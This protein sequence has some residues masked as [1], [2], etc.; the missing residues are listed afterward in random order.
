MKKRNGLTNLFYVIILLSLVGFLAVE[1]GFFNLLFRTPITAF[2]RH[3]NRKYSEAKRHEYQQ[4]EE[5]RNCFAVFSYHV[6]LPFRIVWQH[7]LYLSI[8]SMILS[9]KPFLR[10]WGASFT[11]AS[12]ETMLKNKKYGIMVAVKA[13][14]FVAAATVLFLYE[15][16]GVIRNMTVALVLFV[17]FYFIQFFISLDP[18][19]ERKEETEKPKTKKEKPKAEEDD[20]GDIGIDE[21]DDIDDMIATVEQAES[22][23]EDE[24]GNG[25]TATIEDFL[26]DIESDD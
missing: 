8:L 20:A 13:V 1:F 6:P 22:G 11:K 19:V 16:F 25:N 12:L 5:F 4:R 18:K 14:L 23:T 26:F 24:N 2:R 21:N 7:P 10:S 15:P 17:V 9:I 3:G